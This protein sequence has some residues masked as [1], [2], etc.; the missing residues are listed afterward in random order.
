MPLP[1]HNS[2]VQTNGASGLATHRSRERRR[3]INMTAP[4]RLL[5]R[6]SLLA[7]VAL[8]AACGTPAAQA[9]QATSA[10][11]ATQAPAATAA[12]AQPAANGPELTM[13]TWKVFHVPGLEAVAK[14]FEAKEGI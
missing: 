8:V 6:L 9:P 7:V 2:T 13:W 4:R 1:P 5:S 12:P 14:N 3:R 10:P 11:A